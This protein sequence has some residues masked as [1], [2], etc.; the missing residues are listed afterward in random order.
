ML[1]VLPFAGLP[2]LRTL[3]G[4]GWG[5][6]LYLAIPCTI[7]GFAL[8]T[9]L[10]SHLPATTVGFTIFLNPPMTTGYKLLLTTLFPAVF[11]FSVVTGEFVGGALMLSGVAVAVNPY[12]D[13][14]LRIPSG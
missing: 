9:W 11:A 5:L 2:E 3:D 12:R 8:W 4:T 10:L 13:R 14:R 1:F 6:L 7:I